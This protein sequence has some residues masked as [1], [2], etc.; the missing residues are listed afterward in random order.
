[1]SRLVLHRHLSVH[2][3]NSEESFSY[4]N[5]IIKANIGRREIE[6]LVESIGG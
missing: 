2:I 1:M 3:K 6:T 5:S 4:K